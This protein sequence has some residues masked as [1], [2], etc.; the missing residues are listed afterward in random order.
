MRANVALCALSGVACAASQGGAAG[1]PR[2]AAGTGGDQ[3][4]SPARRKAS[5]DPGVPAGPVDADLAAGRL[6]PHAGGPVR[7][8][9]R[10]PDTARRPASAH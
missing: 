7:D 8:R 10:R 4:A 1:Q 6:A 9:R 3:A 2:A 5:A